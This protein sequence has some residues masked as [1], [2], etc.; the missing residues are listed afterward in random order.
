MARGEIDG[1]QPLPRVHRLRGLEEGSARCQQ[2][3]I[4]DSGA[5]RGS[6]PQQ[7]G[8]ILGHEHARG[9]LVHRCRGHILL[10]DALDDSIIAADCLPALVMAGSPR[11]DLPAACDSVI[12]YPRSITF[13]ACSRLINVLHLYYIKLKIVPSHIHRTPFDTVQYNP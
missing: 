10:H 6:G 5:D 13:P 11:V 7:P 8:G 2:G 3:R 9:G 4:D 1:S 12:E